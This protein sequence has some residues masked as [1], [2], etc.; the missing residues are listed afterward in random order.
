LKAVKLDKKAEKELNKL[1]KR[2]RRLYSRIRDELFSL[3]LE[4]FKGK[5][6]M[7]DKK[8]CRRIRIGDYRVIYEIIGNDVLIIK[9]GHRREVY[10]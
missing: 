5:M 6:L 8:S 4:P 1:F 7:G 10:K 3:E 2:D 9:I